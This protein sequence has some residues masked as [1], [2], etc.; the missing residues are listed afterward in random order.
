MEHAA[1]MGLH[2]Y[3][4]MGATSDSMRFRGYHR[5]RKISSAFLSWLCFV[6]LHRMRNREDSGCLCCVLYCAFIS[7]STALLS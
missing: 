5:H 3:Q 4:S 2:G 7:L 6:C 1:S